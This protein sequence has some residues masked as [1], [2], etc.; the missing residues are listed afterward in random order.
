[1]AVKFFEVVDKQGLSKI[2]EKDLYYIF[3]VDESTGSYGME[4]A[5]VSEDIAL[6]TAS[7][8]GRVGKACVCV[9]KKGSKLFTVNQDGTKL[10][11]G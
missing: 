6:A 4:L 5:T 7:V 9:F 11:M 10:L 3:I 1:M 2:T 8:Y